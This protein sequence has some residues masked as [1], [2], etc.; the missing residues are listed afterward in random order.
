MSA[1]ELF[2]HFACHVFGQ[3]ALAETAF[4]EHVAHL[5]FGVGMQQLVESRAEFVPE[6]EAAVLVVAHDVVVSPQLVGE[7]EYLTLLVDIRTLDFGSLLV[8]V[9]ALLVDVDATADVFGRHEVLLVAHMVARS[10]LL[11]LST[12]V[13]N[14][15]S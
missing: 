14:Y 3:L 4:P 5:A 2:T 12:T 1:V 13:S 8:G 9:A 11:A 10:L 7:I 15:G 6:D